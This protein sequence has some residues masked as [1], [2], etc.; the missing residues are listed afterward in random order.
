MLDSRKSSAATSLI[1]G[2]IVVLHSMQNFRKLYENSPS[3]VMP[4]NSFEA[5]GRRFWSVFSEVP[6]FIVAF[7]FLNF[8]DMTLTVQK[9][10]DAKIRLFYGRVTEL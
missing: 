9:L 5:V 3:L 10:T 7:D 4:L 6:L 1:F 2:I 8:A